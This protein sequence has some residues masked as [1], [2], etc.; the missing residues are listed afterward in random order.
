MR[1]QKEMRAIKIAVGIMSVLILVGTTVLVVLVVKR[2]SNPATAPGAAA[3]IALP[4]AIGT[5]QEPEGTAIAAIAAVG[6]RLA[7]Q[8][9]G[10]GPDRVIFLDPRTATVSGRISLGR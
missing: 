6:D 4:A 5:L 10:G 8:L 7:V 9:R 2:A 1:G 3:A